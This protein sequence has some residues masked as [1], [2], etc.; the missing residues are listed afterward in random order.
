MRRGTP[1]AQFILCLQNGG[2]DDLI[3]RKIYEVLPDRKARA[4]GL[5]RVIDES[6]GDY[7]YPAELFAKV[8][9]PPEAKWA[10]VA[11]S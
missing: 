6:G 7:L 5:L 9:A 1:G 10:L 8:T 11:A 3:P 4:D 2:N